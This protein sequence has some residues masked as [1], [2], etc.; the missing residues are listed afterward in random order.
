MP[1]PD[2][3]PPRGRPAR[4]TPRPSSRPAA[5]GYAP[6]PPR[7]A[8][9]RG[10]FT[11]G[12]PDTRDE[13]RGPP[14]VPDDGLERLQKV[15]AAAGLGS[16]RA[17]EELITT[18]RVEVDRKVVTQLGT[19]VDPHAQEIRVDG[20]KLPEPEAGRLH[21]QQAGRRRDH[22][23]R[24]LR[25][26]ARRRSRAGRA[27]AVR[28][29]PARPHERRADPV[30]NDGELANLL[31]HPRYG[32]EKKYLVQVA[33]VPSEELLE[34]LR[35]GIRL[36]EGEVHAKR[37]SIRSQ[38]KQSAVLE[39]VLDE[40]KNR[41]IRR[42]LAELGHKVH[43][44]KR[45]AVGGLS[46]GRSAARPVA[47]AGL[48]RDRGPPARRHRSR[49]PRRRREP[50]RPRG[51]A[52]RRPGGRPPAAARD[53]QDAPG[54]SRRGN[55]TLGGE[56]P[57]A[58]RPVSCAGRRRAGP[59]ACPGSGSGRQ[60]VELAAARRR[61]GR[62]E[63][64]RGRSRA[65][66]AMP[67]RPPACGPG[68]CSTAQIADGTWRIRLDCP[69][70]AAAGRPRAVRDAADSRPPR[71]APGPAAGRLR[72]VPT[73]RRPAPR[74]YADFIYLVHG[75]VHDRTAAHAAG[76]RT[77]RL[78]PAGQRVPACRRSTTS[79]SWPAASARRPCSPGPRAARAGGLRNRLAD[80]SP[81]ARGHVLLGRTPRA[82]SFGDDRRL[83]RRRVSTCIWPRSTAPPARGASVVDLLDQR[84]RA[85]ASLPRRR[86]SPAADPSR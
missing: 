23:L 79:C 55:D 78:G 46:L 66:C 32:V 24:S 44:L 73:P 31:A 80:A 19:R 1:A 10:P 30:T 45:V 74:H 42:M 58:V 25:P 64:D 37:V 63:H 85:P 83:P 50:P 52:G 77:R 11:R 16:R 12:R 14:R 70:I 34:K 43:Q 40:G 65:P 53:R 35:R 69:A 72:H 59:A 51:P 47:A 5:G 36:A 22:Q 82:A 7:A 29:R 21:A 41:E 4:P 84:S 56:T 6:R 3:R 28:H 33:G 18:G 86:T 9:G 39:M 8:G 48:E 54:P 2:S 38:H 71:S 57:T 75:T 15:L 17:C 61:A 60:G 20:E 27:A 26:P 68:S 67:M 13:G 76:R 81:A 62:S 49:R